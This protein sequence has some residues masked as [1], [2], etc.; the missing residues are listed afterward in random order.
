MEQDEAGTMTEPTTTAGNGRSAAEQA[1]DDALARAHVPPGMVVQS[2][3]VEGTG[4][5]MAAAAAESARA[6][7]DGDLIVE[8]DPVRDAMKRL[9][10]DKMTDE[11]MALGL[12]WLLSDDQEVNTRELRVRA[13]GSDAAQVFL[14]WIIRAANTDEIRQSEREGDGTNRAQRR[15]GGEAAEPDQVRA[16]LRLICTAT[17]T[18]NGRPLGELSNQ[19]GIRDPAVWLRQRFHYRA[20]L[21]P[22]LANQV[23]E[24]SGFAQDDVRAVGNS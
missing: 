23:M 3:P 5:R 10:D 1:A 21:I 2:A 6:L 9:A 7:P 20:G 17:I 24:L 13:G 14:S 22:A 19:K 8:S 12:D 15:G 18:V 4:A 16:S 11:D